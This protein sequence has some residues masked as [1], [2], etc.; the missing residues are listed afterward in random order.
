MLLAE[1]LY[2]KLVKS[3]KET[4]NQIIGSFRLS[5]SLLKKIKKYPVEDF[6]AGHLCIQFNHITLLL[7]NY[8]SPE[9]E[10]LS[11]DVY[12]PMFD[13]AANDYE[14]LVKFGAQKGISLPDNNYTSFMSFM[15]FFSMS[16]VCFILM[17]IV[18]TENIFK[19]MT[20]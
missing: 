16:Y 3:P 2:I 15:V 11:D 8:L 14:K 17:S 19:Y 9:D 12:C 20:K 13:T 10:Y 6:L 1:S 7:F 18:F 4:L 5:S